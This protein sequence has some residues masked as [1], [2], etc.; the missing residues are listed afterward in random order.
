MRYAQFYKYRDIFG[1]IE[2][3]SNLAHEEEFF[4]L[5]K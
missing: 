2:K 5:L 3:K 4:E 1:L